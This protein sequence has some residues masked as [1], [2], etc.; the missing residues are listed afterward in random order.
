MAWV[1]LFFLLAWPVMEFAAFAQVAEW[2][3]TPLAILGLFLSAFLGMA[4]L[5]GQSFATARRVQAEVNTG[6]M[7][8][9]E[10]FDSAAG[11]LAG[12]LLIVPGYVTDLLGLL[13]LLPP[14]RSLIYGEL[15]FLVKSS[16]KTQARSG[17]EDGVQDVTI[18]EADYTVIS[19]GETSKPPPPRD[20]PSYDG[21][22]GGGGGGGKPSIRLLL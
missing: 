22:G 8:V 10:L 20:P 21:G 12:L 5:R 18:I 1:F 14:V 9:R 13:L 11:L 17:S 4:V 6:R 2:V 19:Q 16:L 7:P 15:S 3:G